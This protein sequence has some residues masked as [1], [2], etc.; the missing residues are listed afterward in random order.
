[1][2]FAEIDQLMTNC[3]HDLRIF[4]KERGY[5]SSHNVAEPADHYRGA[6]N[7]RKV[8]PHAIIKTENMP[9]S[10]NVTTAVSII[11]VIIS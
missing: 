8:K 11:P 10:L 3:G 5:N 4:L 9:T 1:M 6:H 7:Y 2:W